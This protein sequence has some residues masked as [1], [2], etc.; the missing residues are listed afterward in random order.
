MIERGNVSERYLDDVAQIAHELS[1]DAARLIDALRTRNDARL[2]GFRAKA[3][4]DFEAFLTAEGYLDDRPVLGASDIR[5]QLL[6]TPAA[7][8]LPDAIVAEFSQRW[9]SLCEKSP[10]TEA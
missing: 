10:A 4:T 8:R 7:S 6:A 3:A 9:W 2:Q 1:G 5:T